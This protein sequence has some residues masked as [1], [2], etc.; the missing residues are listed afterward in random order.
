MHESVDVSAT[1][2]SGA[3]RVAGAAAAGS[4]LPES[5]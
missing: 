2:V 1:D 5:I 3:E 4:G